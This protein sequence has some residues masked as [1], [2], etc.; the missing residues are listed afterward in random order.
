VKRHSRIDGRAGHE[1]SY[2][3]RWNRCAQENIVH[4]DVGWWIAGLSWTHASER[5]VVD[6]YLLAIDQKPASKIVVAIARELAGSLWA[7]LQPEPA[8][9]A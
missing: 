8:A 2:H 7:A 5:A 6:D 1:E 3:V 4:C 9:V